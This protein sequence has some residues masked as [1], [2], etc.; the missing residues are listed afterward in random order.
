[1]LNSRTIIATTVFAA[2]GFGQIERDPDV[3]AYTERGEGGVRAAIAEAAP[4]VDF[5][6]QT[7]APT[8]DRILIQQRDLYLLGRFT[9]TPR[10]SIRNLLSR[11]AA[12]AEERLQKAAEDQRLL[13]GIVHVMLPDWQDL[14]TSRYKFQFVSVELL[15]AVRCLVYDVRPRTSSDDSFTG[16]IYIEDQTYTI[17]RFNG[18]SPQFDRA[19]AGLRGADTR[20]HIDSW[21]VNVAKHQWVPAVTYLQEVAPLGSPAHAFVKGQVRFWGYHDVRPSEQREFV[22]LELASS[23]V[24]VKGRQEPPSPQENQRAFETQAE[25]NVIDR[26]YTGK[27]TGKAGTVEKGLEQIVTNLVIGGN[28][29]LP[30]PIRCRILLTT[31]LESFS[32]GNTIF[33]SRGLI[34]VLPTES[35]LALVIAHQLGHRALGHQTVDTDLAFANVLDVPDDQLLARLRFRH[36]V[37]EEAAAD[38]FAL[39]LLENSPYAKQMAAAGLAMEAIQIHANNLDQLIEPHFGE[40]IADVTHTRQSNPMFRVAPVYNPSLGEQVAALP[41]GAKLL[42]HPWDGSVELLHPAQLVAP[43]P[44]ERPEFAVTAVMPT[45]E[46]VDDERPAPVLATS[47]DRP[48]PAA[49]PSAQAPIRKTIGVVA[50]RDTSDRPGRGDSPALA[51]PRR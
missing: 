34:D 14:S 33:L 48:V 10:P 23:P 39:K 8:D 15:G 36:T 25:R 28:L 31:P 30:A 51:G 19:L 44:R 17:V 46:Y 26:L 18:L 22:A 47:A 12:T 21:R 50:N 37:A 3:P 29:T 1:M 6:A 4:L 9:Y 5:Y 32:V 45:L 38:K 42:L 35:A 13:D 2:L 41:L 7:V 27:F 20:F 43:A 16:R 24:T 49:R 40:H 11:D